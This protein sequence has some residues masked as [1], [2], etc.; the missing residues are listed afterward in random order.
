MIT[1]YKLGIEAS[2]HELIAVFSFKNTEGK[3]FGIKRRLPVIKFTDYAIMA[4]FAAAV[5]DNVY[6]AVKHYRKRRCPDAPIK[7]TIEDDIY[8]AI[9]NYLKTLK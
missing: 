6:L 4:N 2:E 7:D 9:I 5:M 8:L 3:M 1:F